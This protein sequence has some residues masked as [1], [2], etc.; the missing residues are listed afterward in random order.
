[1]S[2]YSGGTVKNPTYE[3]VSAGGTGHLE[4]VRVEYE[5]AQVSYETLLS[6]YWHHIDPTDPYGAFCDKGSN[7]LSA[8][9]YLDEA[10]KKAA[11]TSKAA[12]EKERALQGADR[13]ANPPR[14]AV[15]SRRKRSPGLRA[16]ESACLCELP[17]RLPP[18]RGAQAAVGRRSAEVNRVSRR[19]RLRSTSCLRERQRNASRPVLAS[20]AR[21]VTRGLQEIAS[22]VG[23][24][25]AVG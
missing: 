11:E 4:S 20:S 13:H 5:P 21:R 15:L 6:V 10:Q 24:C 23:A 22:A 25:G 12:L 3:E 1:M 9:F 18:R 16:E 2:G 17:H 8:I 7:Y 14:G 19:P